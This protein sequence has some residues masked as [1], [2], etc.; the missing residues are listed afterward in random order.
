MTKGWLA[1][2]LILTGCIVGPDYRRPYAEVPSAFHATVEAP[3]VP[4][5]FTWWR[6]FGDPVL[7]QLVFE[8]LRFN[9]ELY[10]ATQRVN[11]FLG[12][13]RI[14]RSDLYPRV[15]AEALYGRERVSE[16]VTPIPA[17]IRN[18]DDIYSVLI[19][20]SWEIDFWGKLRRATQAACAELLA[21][22]EAR[23]SVIQTL[24]TAVAT[25]YV[26]ILR[27]DRQLE[28]AKETAKTRFET[29]E[30]FKQQYEAGVIS[31]ISLS[32]IKSQY[33]EALA[34][35]PFFEKLIVQNENALSV[36]L[37]SNPRSIPRG[38]T[39]NTLQMPLIPSGIPSELLS[40][41]P[42]IRE[43]EQLLI[44]A[45]AR[46]GVAKAAYFPT[47][48]LTGAYG[49]SSRELSDLFTGPARAWNYFLPISVPIFTAGQ[50]A[51][52]VRAATARRQQ[53]LG[54]YI[55]TIQ[56]AFREVEDALI[57][58]QKLMEEGEA[59]KEQVAAL[60]TYA[61]L[62]RM[63]YDEGYTSYLEVLDA[64]RS[65]FNVELEYT[66]T[67]GDQFIALIST[68]KALGGIWIDEAD[69]WTCCPTT[70]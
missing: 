61:R 10:V 66:D 41:R 64:E 51:G 38:S 46:I 54:N 35:I 65:L 4:P 17:G 42:D 56:N 13:Y 25:A 9:Q 28:I 60:E 50:I 14:T 23:Q 63:R 6:E 22:V 11:E 53:A 2:F 69:S 52:E 21:T 47:I 67:I 12:L 39:I 40:A 29:L 19:S 31:M 48:T 57:D 24:V 37:G 27:L 7:D 26:D 43:A 33:Q 70:P 5:Q 55:G 20:T 59:Q 15:D 58:Y 18:P 1:L 3:S 45:N 34:A 49:F 62:S 30:L 32:Q 8:A 44:A 36:L 68:Y 16:K